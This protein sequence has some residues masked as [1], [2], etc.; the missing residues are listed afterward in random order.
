[1]YASGGFAQSALWVQVVADVFGRPVV[2][3]DTVESSALGA[4]LVAMKHQGRLAH[5]ADAQ[6][7][8]A[9]AAEYQPRPA[10]AETYRRGFAR[11][12]QLYEVLKP[13]GVL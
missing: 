6:A 11:F 12:K 8:I 7:L 3:A 5:W 1:V 2:V 4:V 13:L 9:P 10:L